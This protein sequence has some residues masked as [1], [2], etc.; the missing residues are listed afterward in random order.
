MHPNR[1]FRNPIGSNIKKVNQERNLHVRMPDNMRQN[2]GSDCGVFAI[3]N[4]VKFCFSPQ[5]LPVH[6]KVVYDIPK[7]RQHAHATRFPKASY[8][9]PTRRRLP[10]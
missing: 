3:A 4:A 6:F 2:N 1:E 8:N 7:M 9:L 10:R 5:M